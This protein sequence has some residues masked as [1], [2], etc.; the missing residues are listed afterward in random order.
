[1]S[2]S[3]ALKRYEM[4]SEEEGASSKTSANVIKTDLKD[5]GVVGIGFIIIGGVRPLCCMI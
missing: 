1:M 3:A 2:R 5:E 4:E